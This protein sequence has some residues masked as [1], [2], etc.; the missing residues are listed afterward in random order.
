MLKTTILDN[1]IEKKSSLDLESLISLIEEVKS[2]ALTEQ[3]ATLLAPD[4]FKNT[5]AE[6]FSGIDYSSIARRPLKEGKDYRTLLKEEEDIS[7][8]EGPAR[9]R[10]QANHTKVLR[11]RFWR[12]A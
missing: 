12:H 7:I 9:L 1:I 4:F 5:L 10:R 11:I 3:Q 8:E 2:E 6:I